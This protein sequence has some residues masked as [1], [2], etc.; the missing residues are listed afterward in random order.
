MYDVWLC[1][2][3]VEI[4]IEISESSQ[5]K[6]VRRIFETPVQL[7]PELLLLTFAKI[8]PRNGNL[9]LDELISIMMPSMLG[10]SP[11]SI[12]LLKRMWDLNKDLVVRSICELCRH[13]QKVINLSRVL[14]IT[15]EIKDSLIEI[16]YCE[17][18]DFA[19]NLGILAGKRDFLHYDQWLKERIKGV[20]T[21]FIKALIHYVNVN[22]I[23]PCREH[24]I[25]NNISRELIK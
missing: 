5:N 15:Q 14:D 13:E 25:K 16:V 2:D 17:D 8:R 9:L 1:N 21:P 3:L 19:V 24:V 7:A 11:N 18:Y 22:V 23:L 4:L 6:I 20:G 10:N 12:P